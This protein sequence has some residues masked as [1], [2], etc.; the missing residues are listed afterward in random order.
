MQITYHD[1]EDGTA[2][3]ADLA[4]CGGDDVQVWTTAIPNES[5]LVMNFSDGLSL[6]ELQRAARFRSEEP[7]LEFLFGRS[8][9]R[10]LLAARLGITPD[11]IVFDYGSYGKPFLIEPVTGI[12]FQFSIT[13]S[14]RYLAIALSHGRRVGIDIEPI[15]S[16]GDWL[17][18][19]RQFYASTEVDA[20][21]A[22]PVELHPAAF[23]KA[24]TSKE[25]LLKAT[26]EGLS[27]GLSGVRVSVIPGCPPRL[28]DY[29]AVNPLGAQWTIH[30]VQVPA[31]MVGALVVE[32][33]TVCCV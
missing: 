27:S 4:T 30:A 17:L 25:A 22:L 16:D 21:L 7:R 9:L 32:G 8:I 15:Q 31:G 2:A 23:F 29:H 14:N 20:M 5:T 18:M 10:R 11:V 6:D 26:G 13:H 1:W 24:W 28:L 33:G 19:A 12:D 3:L